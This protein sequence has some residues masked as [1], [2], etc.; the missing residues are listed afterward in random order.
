MIKFHCWS[1]IY[2]IDRKTRVCHD[3]ADINMC[4]F[5]PWSKQCPIIRDSLPDISCTPISRSSCNWLRIYH[6]AWQKSILVN[7]LTMSNVLQFMLIIAWLII[8]VIKYTIFCCTNHWFYYC[9]I[10]NWLLSSDKEMTLSPWHWFLPFP[11]TLKCSF[12]TLYI[13]IYS[14]R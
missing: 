7:P 4:K 3:I 10:R 9:L 11:L 6:D 8:F 2:T 12:F 14:W 13:Y 1:N 5:R